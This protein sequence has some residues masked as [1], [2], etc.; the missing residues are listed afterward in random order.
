MP[1]LSEIGL[2]ESHLSAALWNYY[3]IAHCVVDVRLLI[4]DQE[5]IAWVDLTDSL[6]ALIIFYLY[7]ARP[8][9]VC[10]ADP[11]PWT[12]VSMIRAHGIDASPPWSY[13]G[14]LAIIAGQDYTRTQLAL[15]KHH[16]CDYDRISQRS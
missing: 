1:G 16:V 13:A 10:H 5:Y 2:P 6:F 7:T 11:L 9:S 4:T 8:A 3:R 15:I 12:H 14:T